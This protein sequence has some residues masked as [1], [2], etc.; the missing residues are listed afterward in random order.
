[1]RI[2]LCL[3]ALVA[4]VVSA[5]HPQDDLSEIDTSV[6]PTI[7][8]PTV[9]MPLSTSLNIPVTVPSIFPTDL[10]ILNITSTS[11]KR[12]SHWE[13][14]PIFSKS[15]DCPALATVPYPCWAT[16]SLQVG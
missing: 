16:D 7:V 12:K 10:P 15:C 11:R 8:T 4:L 9:A 3:A 1:M 6:S 14:I 13:P 2:F 5:P